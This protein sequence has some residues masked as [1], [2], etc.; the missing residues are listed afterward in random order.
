M[1]AD[2]PDQ[3]ISIYDYAET[4]EGLFDQLITVLSTAGEDHY[5]TAK[6]LHSSFERWAGFLGVFA[7]QHVSL[8]TRLES[9]P[10]IHDRFVR[11]LKVV[12][13]NAKHGMYQCCHRKK[14]VRSDKIFKL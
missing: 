5:Q 12:E 13:R 8:D 7:A 1:A 6:Q 14:P 9:S 2:K 4:C 10:Q 3:Q 11:L